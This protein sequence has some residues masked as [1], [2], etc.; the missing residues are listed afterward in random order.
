VI[1]AV[2]RTHHPEIADQERPAALEGGIGLDRL[3]APQVSRVADGEHV[4]CS[5]APRSRAISG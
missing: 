4:L 3:Q 5:L 1:D 2:L